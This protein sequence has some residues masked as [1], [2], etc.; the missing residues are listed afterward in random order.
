MNFTPKYAS[1]MLRVDMTIH[2]SSSSTNN[3]TFAASL[4]QDAVVNALSTVAAREGSAN[5]NIRHQ[6]SMTVFVAAVNTTLRAFKIRAGTSIAGTTTFNNASFG[7]TLASQIT[8]TEI[9]Q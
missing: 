9:A 6:L 7:G 1:S 3:A 4:F 2:L 8:I 5:A